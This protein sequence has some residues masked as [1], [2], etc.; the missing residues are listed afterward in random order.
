MMKI[1][2]FYQ[3]MRYTENDGVA[4]VK[5]ES[6]VTGEGMVTKSMFALME[7]LCGLFTVLEAKNTEA[8]K[9]V[10]EGNKTDYFSAK[11]QY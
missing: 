9:K 4:T 3:T 8:L 11:I 5:T 2:K 1:L 10:I 6:K 7:M